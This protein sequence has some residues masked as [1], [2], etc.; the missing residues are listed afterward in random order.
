MFWRVYSTPKRPVR[1]DPGIRQ[2]SPHFLFCTLRWVPF[3]RCLSDWGGT[4]HWSCRRRCWWRC[5]LH[6]L[7]WS[8]LA[9]LSTATI[10]R[11]K[12]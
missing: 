4:S 8:T 2:G 9:K 7:R 3:G 5:Q 1:F 12:S 10:S 11:V 6:L